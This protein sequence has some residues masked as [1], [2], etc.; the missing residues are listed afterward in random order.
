[1]VKPHRILVVGAKHVGKTSLIHELLYYSTS[2]G[3]QNGSE[4]CQS[5]EDFYEMIFE[6]T[7]DP[8]GPANT[9]NNSNH[10]STNNNR[11]PPTP[12]AH[13][14][15]NIRLIDTE[16]V[17]SFSE[18]PKYFITKTN[19]SNSSNCDF[20]NIDGVIILYSLYSSQSFQLATSLYS[21][22]HRKKDSK[23]VFPLMLLGMDWD[24]EVL[25]T[26]TSE[27][28][29]QSTPDDGEIKVFAS[30]ANKE[31]YVRKRERE[32]TRADISQWEQKS[33]L[34]SSPTARANFSHFEVS[35]H[36]RDH[37]LS[38]FTHFISKFH[39]TTKSGFALPGFRKK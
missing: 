2:L 11:S 15:D 26:A 1:M 20:V 27:L 23:N 19:N 14:K 3:K 25:S 31:N 5:P 38:C 16:G 24:F 33:K 8:L 6:L 4:H 28:S 37:L 18:L 35:L 17:T 34:F 36:N 12:A 7:P 29:A 39:A 10:S 30:D 13:I 9:N 22:F 32:V 21:E